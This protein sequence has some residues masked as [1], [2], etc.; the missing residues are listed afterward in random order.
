MTALGPGRPKS[1][2][3]AGRQL[4]QAQRPWHIGVR[5]GRPWR[6]RNQF[7]RPSERLLAENRIEGP[8][9]YDRAFGSPSAIL[10][11]RPIGESV[12]FG[13]APDAPGGCRNEK[14]RARK[15]EIRGRI[16]R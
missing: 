4:T 12:A 15:I 8:R 9:G 16:Q 13:V 1:G 5:E 11:V 7:V 3:A 6:W 14:L 2:G 10:P